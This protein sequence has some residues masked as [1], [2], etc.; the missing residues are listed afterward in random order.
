MG[1]NLYAHMHTMISSQKLGVRKHLLH[2]VLGYSI[3]STAVLTFSMHVFA[4]CTLYIEVNSRKYLPRIMIRVT[5][6]W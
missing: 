3:M 4:V 1:L 5:L 2:S 6:I